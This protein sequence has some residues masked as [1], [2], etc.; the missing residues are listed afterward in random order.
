MIAPP[1]LILLRTVSTR[2]NIPRFKV[3]ER[4]FGV[5]DPGA[6]Q[7]AGAPHKNGEAPRADPV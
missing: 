7:D 6:R 2:R 3:E 1:L 4:F 5:H